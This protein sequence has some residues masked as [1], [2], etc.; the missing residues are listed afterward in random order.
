M[1]DDEEWKSET[2]FLV[3]SPRE[4]SYLV[5]SKGDLAVTAIEIRK[6][7]SKNKSQILRLIFEG[8]QLQQEF[9]YFVASK[10]T[11]NAPQ[12]YDDRDQPAITLLTI[13]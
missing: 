12:D 2:N 13:I 5:F 7:L 6:K 10:I 11:S 3:K 9:C 1:P 4:V 8:V